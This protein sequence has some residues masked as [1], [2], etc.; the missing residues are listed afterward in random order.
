MIVSQQYEFGFK[1][2]YVLWLGLV[3]QLTPMVV[4]WAEL[5]KLSGVKSSGFGFSSSYI[6]RALLG[7]VWQF[8]LSE[9]HKPFQMTV[10]L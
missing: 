2:N 4:T 5:G 6:G 8:L 9:Q 10:S 3:W 7:N 1:P